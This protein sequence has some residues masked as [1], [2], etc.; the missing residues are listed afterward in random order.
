MRRPG[1]NAVGYIG[2][3][4]TIMLPSEFGYQRPGVHE[5]PVAHGAATFIHL[6]TFY[7]YIL[8]LL[9]VLYQFCL[10]LLQDNLKTLVIQA[11]MYM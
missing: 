7:T 11:Q 10:K 6:G 8:G 9:V 1:C 5:Q 4:V 3:Y 2:A